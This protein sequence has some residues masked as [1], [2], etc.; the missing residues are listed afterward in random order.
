MTTTTGAETPLCLPSSSLHFSPCTSSSL[1]LSREK[2]REREIH[3]TLIRSH[4]RK[5]PITVCPKRNPLLHVVLR[6]LFL[7]LLFFQEDEEEAG[8][9][10]REAGNQV[11]NETSFLFAVPSFLVSLFIPSP[12]FSCLSTCFFMTCFEKDKKPSTPLF[13]SPRPLPPSP[14]SLSQVLWMK[15][16]TGWTRSTILQD[17]IITTSRARSDPFEAYNLLSCSFTRFWKEKK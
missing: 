14:L 4:A 1:V 9:K 7:P 11:M 2:E 17:K 13:S 6:P 10:E 8:Q 15:W 3:V 5:D 16:K 12:Q